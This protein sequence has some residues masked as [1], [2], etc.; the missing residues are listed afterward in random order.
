MRGLQSYFAKQSRAIA[1]GILSVACAIAAAGDTRG[2]IEPRGTKAIA[3][4]RVIEPPVDRSGVSALMGRNVQ[5]SHARSTWMHS[6]MYV[7]ADP[8]DYRK[9][10][11]CSIMGSSQE[12]LVDERDIVYSSDDGGLTWSPRV[13]V[14]SASD[15]TCAYTTNGSALFVAT[16]INRPFRSAI[17]RS[18]DGGS[19]WRFDGEI[20]PLD[21]PAVAAGVTD[22]KASVWIG[23]QDL[24]GI[25]E[26]H[27]SCT[28]NFPLVAVHSSN[29]GETFS[30]PMELIEDNNGYCLTAAGSAT[31]FS[32]DAPAF[33]VLQIRQPA[34]DS[35]NLPDRPN[36]RL[37]IARVGRKAVSVSAVP[38]VYSQPTALWTTRKAAL[39]VDGGGGIF[40]NRM[41]VAWSDWRTGRCEVLLSYSDDDGENW[42]TP[43]IVNDDDQRVVPGRPGPDD[44]QVMLAV[45][46]DGIVG[47]AWYSRADSRDDLG[48][49]VRFR[50]SLTGGRTWLPSVRVSTAPNTLTVPRNWTNDFQVETLGGLIRIVAGYHAYQFFTGG[51]YSGMAADAA[52]VFHPVWADD[53]TGV[54]QMWTARISVRGVVHE[55]ASESD[56]PKYVL[57]ASVQLPPVPEVIGYHVFPPSVDDSGSVP[58]LGRISDVRYDAEAQTFSF[59]LSLTNASERAMRGPWRL[60]VEEVRSSYATVSLECTDNGALTA[61]AMWLFRGARDDALQ[62]AAL[63]APR[64]IILRF[65][66]ERPFRISDF[67]NPAIS[68]PTLAVIDYRISSAGGRAARSKEHCDAELNSDA[69]HPELSQFPIHNSAA[70]QDRRGQK[71]VTSTGR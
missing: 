17:Y 38:D 12:G 49:T 24:L 71:V 32:H 48:W 29:D 14:K 43:R 33:L 26:R 16:L 10:I 62:P 59:N 13:T 67:W 68:P 39:A 23:G 37:G 20:L 34:L 64:R 6:E 46:A 55:V 9:L 27:G 7:A 65:R 25:A 40:H 56:A 35:P 41:Y 70:M 42:A 30:R 52:G 63:S 4:Y 53:R 28:G 36:S 31:L 2:R 18:A 54:S 57:P 50:A 11:A 58:R 51:D 8:R 3:A 61:G 66:R 69:L 60:Y 44:T 45:N 19:T 47:V 1:I 5:V 15:P 22:G 21:H